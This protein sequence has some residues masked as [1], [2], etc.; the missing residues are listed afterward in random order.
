MKY[1]PVK[2]ECCGADETKE[3]TVIRTVRGRPPQV[4]EA[5]QIHHVKFLGGTYPEGHEL[6]GV[7]IAQRWWH[8]SDQKN[9]ILNI[10]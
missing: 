3:T 10:A 8:W 7:P 5:K 2:T 4:K 6:E 1:Y 9:L